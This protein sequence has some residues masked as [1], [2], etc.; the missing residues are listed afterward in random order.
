[1]GPPLT[2]R[3]S[4]TKANSL[5]SS[6][7]ADIVYRLKDEVSYRARTKACH[8]VSKS[9]PRSFDPMNDT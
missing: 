9:K 2:I 5:V 4:M 3:A 8:V 1:M 6:F 7:S